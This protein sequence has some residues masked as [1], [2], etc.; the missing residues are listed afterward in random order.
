LAVV[1]VRQSSPQQV[2]DH[3]E[4]R[5]RQYALADHAV[6][7]GWGRDRVLVIDEDQGQS[8]RSVDQRDGFKR[9][10][11]EVTL[12]H[13]GLVL[14]LEMSRLARS[15]KD[16]HNLLEL[17][18][19]FGTLLGDQDGVYDANDTNDRLLLGL[20][21]TMSEYETF[22]MRNRLQCGRLHKAQR[23]ELYIAV[24]CGYLKTASGPVIQEPDEQARTVI[25]AVFDKFE[26]LGSQYAVFRYLIDNNLRLGVRLRHGPRRG[27]LEWRRPSMA[28]VAQ[29]LH[30]PI[31]AGAYVF[32]WRPA[33]RT[34][35]AARHKR[36]AS[37]DEWQVLKRDHLPAYISWDQYLAN[38][39]RMQA[40]RNRPTSLGAPRR[41]SA[42]LPGL[43]VCGTCGRRMQPSYG[44][45]LQPVYGCKW[46]LMEARVK[47]CRSVNAAVVDGLVARQ[48]LRALEPAALELSLEAEHD[49]HQERQ[50]LHRHWDQQRERAR[51]EV[52]R[53][54]RQYHTV[55]PENRLV[56]RT[57]EKRWEE[58]LRQQQQLQEEYDRFLQG[59]PSQLSAHERDRIRAL[60][61]D[62]PALWN[63]PTTSVL[64]RKEIIRCLVE[65]VVAHVTKDSEYMDVTVHW[66][67]GCTTQHQIVRPV[68]RYVWM[69]DFERL[70]QRLV[71]LRQEGLTSATM[72]ERLNTEG[73]SPPK[74]NG[75]FSEESVRQLLRRQGLNNEK[76]GPSLGTDEWWLPALAGEL[77][78]PAGKLRGWVGR[79]WLHGRQ[80]PAQH[81]WVVWADRDELRRLR[82]LAARSV[83]GVTSQPRE[84]TTPKRRS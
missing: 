11:G 67:G 37:M 20:K 58:A 45:K 43:L 54:E 74:R 66:Q 33:H 48:V 4:S 59:Q 69:R 40:N 76:T 78:M 38:Q 29:I 21:G 81:L 47:T 25:Q 27:E 28:T 31:Y 6:T 42:L 30:H 49:I 46:H 53:A 71:E 60:A 52:E 63:A 57:L 16:W 39:Q 26:E 24:P 36:W 7:L 50:R 65:K 8:G 75:P 13:V 22:T 84:L 62:L 19:L 44:S 55:E 3:Q 41:G 10:L 32:G 1:Y 68:A 83:R 23:G 2:V 82:K 18:A 64:E 61:E 72:A 5:A 79:G 73:F 56:A 35:P 80:T 17:C 15:S 14:G 51:Y 9:L 70:R 12:G 77:K 34:G